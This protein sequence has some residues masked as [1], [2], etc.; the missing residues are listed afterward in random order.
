MG[1]KVYRSEL[2]PVD[3]LRRS[4]YIFLDKTAVV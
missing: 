3:F 1:E 4:A 2:T